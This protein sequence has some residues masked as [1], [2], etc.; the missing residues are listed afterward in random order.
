[1]SIKVNGSETV[2]PDESE[3]WLDPHSE[4]SFGRH[5][6]IVR[7]P[8]G[9]LWVVYTNGNAVREPKKSTL[10]FPGR[11]VRTDVSTDPYVTQEGE[12]S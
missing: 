4:G 6:R 11:W 3:V 7:T 2:F 5:P 9:R 10:V 12:S 8:G 1:M